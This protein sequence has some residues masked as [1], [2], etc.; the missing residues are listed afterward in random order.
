MRN[1]HKLAIILICV[2]LTSCERGCAS[3]EKHNQTSPRQYDVTMYSGGDVVFHDS[4][5]TI[6][7]SEDGS[8]GIY[9]FKG[10]TLIEVS[11][12]YILKST[13]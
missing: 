10:D 3:W 4:V 11:G 9:Y 1:V 13:K 5:Y 2:S 12:D 7:N 6:V 8:D